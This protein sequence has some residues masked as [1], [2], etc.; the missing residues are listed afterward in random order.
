MHI[1]TLFQLVLFAFLKSRSKFQKSRVSVKKQFHCWFVL[2]TIVNAPEIF[3][4]YC[5]IYLKFKYM[6]EGSIPTVVK[7]F[8]AAW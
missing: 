1:K 8:S 3:N 5:D 2:R 4:I 7:E 6:N